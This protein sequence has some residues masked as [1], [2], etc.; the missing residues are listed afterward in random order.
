ML[1]WFNLI[2]VVEALPT[3][4]SLPQNAYFFLGHVAFAFHG[5]GPFWG[6]D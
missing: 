5:L 4:E 2:V 6:P 3:V 1:L